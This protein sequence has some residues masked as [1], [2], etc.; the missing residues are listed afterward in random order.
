MQGQARPRSCKWPSSQTEKNQRKAQRPPGEVRRKERRS[1]N[2]LQL[3]RRGERLRSK[4]KKRKNLGVV[5]KE[6]ETCNHASR[7]YK[8]SRCLRSN[9]VKKAKGPCS[10]NERAAKAGKSGGKVQLKFLK[11]SVSGQEATGK[12]KWRGGTPR[13]GRNQWR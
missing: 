3:G 10:R 1:L 11:F 5:E 6:H 7:A 2:L 13:R 8:L 4:E 9:K 12:T